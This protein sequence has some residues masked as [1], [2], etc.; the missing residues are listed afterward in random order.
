M[1]NPRKLFLV[2]FIAISAIYSAQNNL[3]GPN[4]PITPGGYFDK[5]FDH[6]GNE[7]I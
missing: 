2:L 7:H 4:Q 6:Y 3:L 5:V 1:K